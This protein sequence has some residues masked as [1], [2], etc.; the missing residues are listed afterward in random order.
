MTKFIEAVINRK[1]SLV[2][3]SLISINKN[4][5]SLFKPSSVLIYQLNRSLKEKRVVELMIV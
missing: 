4:N 5:M 3:I 2:G 1:S